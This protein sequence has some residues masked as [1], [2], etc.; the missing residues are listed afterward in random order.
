MTYQP[1]DAEY[2]KWPGL[3][4]PRQVQEP[5]KA[6]S[7]RYPHECA[8]L[9]DLRREVRTCPGW[10]R[11]NGRAGKFAVVYGGRMLSWHDA[12]ELVA[13]GAA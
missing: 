4:R 2:G 8:T 6:D 10:A 9:D 12:A 1:T 5:R 11:G 13:R 7:L 3:V